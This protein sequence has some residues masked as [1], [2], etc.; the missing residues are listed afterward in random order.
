MRNKA[1]ECHLEEAK[2]LLTFLI[3]KG[4]ALFSN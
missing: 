3:V 2:L 4:L 1:N